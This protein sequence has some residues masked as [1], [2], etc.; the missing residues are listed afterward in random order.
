MSEEDIEDVYLEEN[1][2]YGRYYIK[3]GKDLIVP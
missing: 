3:E 1:N 2:S